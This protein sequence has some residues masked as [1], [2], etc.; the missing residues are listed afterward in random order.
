MADA[1]TFYTKVSGT[2]DVYNVADL[3]GQL[4]NA[5]IGRLTDTFANSQL[6][7]LD[8]A[9][10]QV[11]LST[12]IAAQL[13]PAFSELGLSLDTFV[14]EN[15]SLPDVL[16]QV[17]DQRIQ[18]NIVGDM[19]RYTR[20]QAAQSV[21]IAAANEG[22]TSGL[23]AGLGVGVAMGQTIADAVRTSLA[24]SVGAAAVPGA[25]QSAAGSEATKF[26]IHCGKQVPRAAS[27]CSECGKPQQ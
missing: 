3:E 6:A 12:Q 26:C 8:M 2:R 23:G 4:R 19:G 7:F 22:G 1:K 27:F 5:I 25:P 15:L 9:A 17:L 24:S 21:P 11:A 14:V 13:K 20:F 16:Q 10:N 18:M